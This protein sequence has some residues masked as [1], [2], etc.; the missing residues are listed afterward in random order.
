[1]P[2]AVIIVIVMV[3]VL[4]AAI[5]LAGAVWSAV[6]GWAFGQGEDAPTEGDAAS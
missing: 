2:G 3:L 6:F 4:P 1:M 5:M